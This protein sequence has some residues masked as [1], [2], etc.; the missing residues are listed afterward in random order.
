MKQL[1]IKHL[2]YLLIFLFISCNV[3]EK[4][5]LKK[6]RIFLTIKNAST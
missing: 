2:L 4:L 3:K 5:L 6:G 1:Q